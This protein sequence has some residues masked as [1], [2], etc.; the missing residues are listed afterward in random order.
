MELWHTPPALKGFRHEKHVIFLSFLCDVQF[1]LPDI[2]QNVMGTHFHADRISLTL[3]TAKC[4]I[5]IRINEA[6]AERAGKHTPLA[7]DTKIS[8]DGHGVGFW[9]AMG[10]AGWASLFT[11]GMG[12]IVA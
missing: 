11:R 2:G 12:A 1:G 9:I 5:G 6:G 7:S 8:V 3:M 10:C 4:F